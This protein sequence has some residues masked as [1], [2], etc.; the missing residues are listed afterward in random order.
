M[1]NKFKQDQQGLMSVDNLGFTKRMQDDI[2]KFAASPNGMMIVTGPTGHG[3][4]T[5]L[6]AILNKIDAFQRNIVT[7]EDPVEYQLENINQTSDQRQ[8]GDHVRRYAALDAAPG[9][10]RHPRRRDPRQRDGRDRHAGGDDG[11]PRVLDA[12]HGRRRVGRY[13]GF[14]TSASSRTSYPPR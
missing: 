14:S 9:P 4:T 6:Y 11:A 3:K 2:L 1:F 10:R 7:V 12:A 5:T 13:S 8:G